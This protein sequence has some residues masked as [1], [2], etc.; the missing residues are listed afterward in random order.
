MPEWT[1][2]WRQTDDQ[3]YEKEILAALNENWPSFTGDLEMLKRDEWRH[4]VIKTQLG[5]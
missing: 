3:D 4:S 2:E 1:P 5:Q